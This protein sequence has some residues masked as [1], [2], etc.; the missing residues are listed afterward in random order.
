MKKG[1][2]EPGRRVLF[3]EIEPG[4]DTCRGEQAEDG[5]PPL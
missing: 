5:L 3:W 2:E 1:A 4:E